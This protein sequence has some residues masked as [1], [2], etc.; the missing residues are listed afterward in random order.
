MGKCK[1]KRLYLIVILNIIALL[2]LSGCWSNK[3]IE[4]LN[5]IVGS[6][7]DIEPNREIKSTLQYVIPEAMESKNGVSNSQ[8]PYI[9]VAGK[10]ISLE[11]SGW[12]TT[13]SR[14]GFIF[15]SHQKV[16]LISD[17]LARERKL[18]EITDLYY[19]D[20]DIRGSTLI[21]IAKGNA[22]QALETKE[23]N[24][25]PSLRIAEIANE[26]LTSEIVNKS[27]LIKIGGLMN[28]SSS[29]L[30][31][32]LESTKEGVRFTGAALFKGKTNKM[33]G[34]INTQEVEGIN[35]ITGQGKGGTVKAFKNKSDGP[36]YY[37]IE[38]MKSKI[39]PHIKGDKLSFDVKI[40]SEGRVAEYW[41]PHLRPLFNEKNIKKIEK[42]TENVIQSLVEDVTKRMQKE[43]KIDVAGFGNQLRIKYPRKWNKLKN[44]WDEKFTKASIKYDVDITIKDYGMI[45]K[46]KNK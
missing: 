29:F 25:I 7:L 19:R 17:E 41:N 27:S 42:N 16:V 1:S 39:I 28:S 38:A 21:F 3:P 2:L 8:K 33:I 20:I 15:G 18:R 10:G 11:P 34:T 32:L 31:Q 26:S 36:T 9:N 30:L 35:W 46:K 22:G 45:G 43:F 4:D 13:L 44:N 40:E 6:A 14:E 12:E 24:V 23:I 5:I 37:Q